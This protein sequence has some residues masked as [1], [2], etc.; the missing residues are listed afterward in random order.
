MYIVEF[1]QGTTIFN[2][3]GSLKLIGTDG[4]QL[5]KLYHPDVAKDPQA[6]EKFQAVSEAY[7]VLGDDRKRYVVCR[8]L[9][10]IYRLNRAQESV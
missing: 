10:Q 2:C 6:K 3:S 8:P 5:S 7:A 1:L 9:P 4:L